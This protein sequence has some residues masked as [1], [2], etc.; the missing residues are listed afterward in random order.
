M[1]WIG[2]SEAARVLSIS[3]TA[4]R[5]QLERLEDIGAAKQ[6]GGRWKLRREG[7]EL[8]YDEVVRP[9]SNSPRKG[10]PAPPAAQPTIPGTDAPDEALPPRA[11]GDERAALLA[12]LRGEDLPPG[13]SRT[14]A[15]RIRAIAQARLSQLD[16]EDREGRL[17]EAEA[18]G[19]QWFEAG[20]R[21]RDQVLSLPARISADL[22]AEV[23]P[24]KVA[25]LL[26]KSLT[27][28]LESMNGPV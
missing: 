10:V 5:R 26:E 16:V 13:T 24:V 28:C 23:D 14:E 19:R 18:V 8:A 7:L 3:R 9:C 15:E 21:V 20:R 11:P 17:V 27:Q 4:L 1:R 25:I 12:Q 6:D 2:P 22:A